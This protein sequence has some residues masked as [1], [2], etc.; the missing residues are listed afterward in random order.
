LN[1]PATNQ[2]LGVTAALGTFSL[3]GLAPI[4]F[5]WIA[6][7][8]PL[9]I[10]VHRILWSIPC[11]VIFLLLRDGPG[12]WKRLILPRKKLATLLLSGSLIMVN[13]LV[14]VWAINND[15]IL[16][17]SLG[18]F[19]NP[20]LSVLLGYVF[21]QERLTRIQ[22]LAVGLAACGT[23]FLTWY[24]GVAP[25]ISLFLALSFGLYGLVR[26]KLGVG[27]MV[28]LLWETLLMFIPAVLYLL[29]ISS[30]GGLVFGTTTLKLDLLLVAAGIVTVLPLVWFN[31]AALNLSLSTV[32]FFQY[33]APTITFLLAVFVYGESFTIG[34]AVAFGCIWLALLMVTVESI[35]RGRRL[36]AA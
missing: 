3:W 33:L 9:E 7:A 20:L 6:A 14:F 1:Q 8:P 30:H 28:G 24:L 25:W 21:L 10:I 13:W 23:L 26:K 29:W 12:F 15:R 11:L 22:S 4:Y 5:K 32:G 27:P 35:F 16:A 18:Y 19:I 31:V 36:R 17:T 34:H 2:K